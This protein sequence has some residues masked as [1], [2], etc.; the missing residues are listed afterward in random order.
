MTFSAIFS[1]WN[2]SRRKTLTTLAG[3]LTLAVA[4][5]LVTL[6]DAQG[7][8]PAPPRPSVDF[9]YVDPSQPDDA[10]VSFHGSKR[11]ANGRENRSFAFLAGGK[12]QQLEL[13]GDLESAKEK[14]LELLRTRLAKNA[15]SISLVDQ[16]FATWL[17]LS[18]PI[19]V[20]ESGD[21]YWMDGPCPVAIAR[22]DDKVIAW[23]MLGQR[24]PGVVHVYIAQ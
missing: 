22:R 9:D 11:D 13:A 20:N 21:L 23:A 5:T 4:A 14:V 16:Q 3:C 6:R 18:K 15:N 7:S 8:P 2:K 12:V 17:Q 10:S 1:Q 19:E 24:S